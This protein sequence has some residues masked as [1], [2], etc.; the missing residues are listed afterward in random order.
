[1]AL[2]KHE[3]HVQLIE[4]KVHIGVVSSKGKAMGL[5][6]DL[7]LNTLRTQHCHPPE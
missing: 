7:W 3:S 2:E 5:G 4:E 1:M 6:Q